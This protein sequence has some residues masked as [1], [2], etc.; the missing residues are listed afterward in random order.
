MLPYFYVHL[1]PF[2]DIWWILYAVIG[3]IFSVLLCCA[4][5]NLATLD[6]TWTLSNFQSQKSSL[7]R[8]VGFPAKN[9][10]VKTFW[11]LPPNLSVWWEKR[12]R[13]KIKVQKFST[14]LRPQHA[15]AK[16]PIWFSACQTEQIVSKHFTL[17]DARGDVVLVVSL[18][19]LWKATALKEL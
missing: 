11:T 18:K 10:S 19:W 1:V 2:V 6:S 16:A 8:E 15:H 4:K 9:F 13:T 3:Y 14:F 12:E 5:K 7:A 17:A